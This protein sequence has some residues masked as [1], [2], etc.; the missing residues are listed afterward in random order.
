MHSFINEILGCLCMGRTTAQYDILEE[1]PSLDFTHEKHPQTTESLAAD[2][3]STL[4]AADA[5]DEHLIQRLQDVVHETGWYEGL[6]AA[7]LTGLENALKAEVP[8]GQAMKDAYEKA[9]QIVADVLEF[10]K[11]H[12]VFCAVVALGILVILA[13]WAIEALGFGELGPIEGMC[14]CAAIYYAN[15][16]FAR[17]NLCC[18]VAVEICRLCAGGIIVL[19]L[20]ATGNGLAAEI[21]RISSDCHLNSPE[22]P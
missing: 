15:V 21:G 18:L 2:I 20:P 9:T 4:Y 12:P 13:P 1:Q 16:L 11:E 14:I 7:V 8:I 3:L 10:A 17:R 19:V 5:N 6:A 22:I